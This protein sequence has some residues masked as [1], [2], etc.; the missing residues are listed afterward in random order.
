MN[1]GFIEVE[2][3][4]KYWLCKNLGLRKW[5]YINDWMEIK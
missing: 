2:R 4:V 5:L 3:N 1:E